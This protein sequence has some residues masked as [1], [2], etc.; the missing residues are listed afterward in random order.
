MCGNPGDLALRLSRC[1]EKAEAAGGTHASFSH[2]KRAQFKELF[3]DARP[4]LMALPDPPGRAVGF[5]NLEG[6][7]KNMASKGLKK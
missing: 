5:I 7:G 1:E 4:E 6:K 2:N 3:V